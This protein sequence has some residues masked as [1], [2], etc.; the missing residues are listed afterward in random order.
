MVSCKIKIPK[1]MTQIESSESKAWLKPEKI[2][3]IIGC[4]GRAVRNE[5]NKGK[6]KLLNSVLTKRK[7]YSAD[8]GQQKV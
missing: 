1:K 4:S 7:E 6:V 3:A 2:R 8:I 5:L